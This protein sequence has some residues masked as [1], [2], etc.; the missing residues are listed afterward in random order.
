MSSFDV[1]FHHNF[2]ILSSYLV[3]LLFL[4]II[5]III[6]LQYNKC[7]ECLPATCA[8]RQKLINYKLN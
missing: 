1:T 6:A 3:V 4:F 8:G 7:I 5:I 2:I